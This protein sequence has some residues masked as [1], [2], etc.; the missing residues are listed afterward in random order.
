MIMARERHIQRLVM[1]HPYLLD[2]GLID[3]KGRR[4]RQVSNGRIDVDFETEIGLVVVECKTTCLADRDILQLRRYLKALSDSGQRVVDAYIL[5]GAPRD[6]LDENLLAISPGIK[7]RYLLEHFP[8]EL[9][10]CQERHYFDAADSE[11]N[12]CGSPAIPGHEI[13]LSI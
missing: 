5:A 1:S 13:I 4:E 10:L 8:L 9:S 11:C 12:I 3:H 7:A 6:G 2:P